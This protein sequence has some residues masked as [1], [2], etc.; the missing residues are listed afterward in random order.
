MKTLELNQM[1]SVLGGE[2]CTSE[3]MVSFGAGMLVLGALSFGLGALA[4]GALMAA[5][6]IVKA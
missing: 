5:A 1:E 2:P 6:C 4:Y 3:D